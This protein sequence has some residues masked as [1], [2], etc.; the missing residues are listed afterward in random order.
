MNHLHVHSDLWQ[1]V[2]PCTV[3]MSHTPWLLLMGAH[4]GH[5][6][7]AETAGKRTLVVNHGI[8]WLHSEKWWSYQSE[9]Q[10][11]PFEMYIIVRTGWWFWTMIIVS[12]LLSEVEV[13]QRI[14]KFQDRQ[15]TGLSHPLQLRMLPNL[16]SQLLCG[17][18]AA[19][20]IFHTPGHP[21]LQSAGRAVLLKQPS[22]PGKQAGSCQDLE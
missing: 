7:Q 18:V 14:H 12:C 13:L 20:Q 17:A 16:L 22:Y 4:E 8:S 9:R 19:I 3:T 6:L 11:V 15:G 5:G 10:T 1:T 21:W 2:L